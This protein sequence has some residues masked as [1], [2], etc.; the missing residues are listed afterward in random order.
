VIDL[1]P[2][3]ELKWENWTTE[4]KGSPPSPRHGHISVL[5]KQLY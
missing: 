3:N 5:G 2:E 4:I 1:E